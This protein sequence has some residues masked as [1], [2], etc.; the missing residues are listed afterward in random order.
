MFP[1]QQNQNGGPQNPYAQPQTGVNS[2]P[3]QAPNGQYEVLP[4]LPTANNTGHSGHNPYEFI[5]NPNSGHN[6]GG[7]K[8]KQSF[9]LQIAVLLGG[10]VVIMIIIAVVLSALGPKSSTPGLTAIAQRQ[11]EIARVANEAAAKAS[12]QDTQNFTNNVAVSVA[13]SQQQ[14]LG[15]LSAHGTKLKS[16]QLALDASNQTDATLASANSASNYDGVAVQT[17]SD[18]LKTYESMLQTSY[19][20]TSNAKL[21]AVLQ[22]CYNSAAKLLAQASAINTGTN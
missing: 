19:K 15:Y 18:Q 7:N 20:Q 21:K 3:Q 9:L 1:D 2:A 8:L 12:G 22:G 6:A 17:L 5:V 13:S 10:L 14:V 4:P 16:K 11:Q